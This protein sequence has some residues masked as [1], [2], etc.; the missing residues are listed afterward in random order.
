MKVGCT[1]RHSEFRASELPLLPA[2]VRHDVYSTVC[3]TRR[4]EWSRLQTTLI[5]EHQLS[6]LGLEPRRPTEALM[7][8]ALR[9]PPARRT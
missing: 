7:R 3:T 4:K 5:G 1:R 9:L 6:R 8:G 2:A